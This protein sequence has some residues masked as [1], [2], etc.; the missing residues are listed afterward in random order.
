MSLQRDLDRL[1]KQADK[2]LMNFSEVKCQILH[3]GSHYAHHR[4]RLRKTCWKAALQRRQ[5]AETEMKEIQFKHNKTH[6]TVR[7]V[8]HSNTFSREF[9]E[10]PTLKMLKPK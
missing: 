3:L 2:N 9:M 6:F 5:W 10:C 4:H 1:E 7:V 8:N